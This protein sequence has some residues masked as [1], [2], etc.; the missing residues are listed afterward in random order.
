M[1]LFQSIETCIFQKYAD[2]KGVAPKSEYWWFCLFYLFV[3]FGFPMFTFIGSAFKQSESPGFGEIAL[4]LVWIMI[5]IGALC[6]FIA[7]S[8]RRLHDS[9]LNGLHFLWIFMPYIGFILTAILMLRD[10]K[11]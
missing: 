9:K 7:V 6:P 11:D 8:V 3:T 2:F 5:A 4:M 1:N 10:H